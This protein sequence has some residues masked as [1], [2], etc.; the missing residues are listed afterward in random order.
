MA[1]VGVG[2]GVGGRVGVGVGSVTGVGVGCAAGPGLEA[3]VWVGLAVGETGVLVGA[4]FG[5]WRTWACVGAKVG[6][7]VGDGT[8]V[9]VGLGGAGVEVATSC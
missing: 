8:A 6:A 2:T 9:L 4:A 3:G 7:G 1:G 5:D